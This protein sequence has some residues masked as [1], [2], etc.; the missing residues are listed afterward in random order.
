M[1]PM[2][3]PLL[4]SIEFDDTRLSTLDILC[5]T[6]STGD[7][8]SSDRIDGYHMGNHDHHFLLF[9]DFLNFY[10]KAFQSFHSWDDFL[11]EGI[12]SRLFYDRSELEQLCSFE[13]SAP[14]AGIDCIELQFRTLEHRTDVLSLLSNFFI[15]VSLGFRLPKLKMF[16]IS[17]S[18]C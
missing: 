13:A 15:K 7:W 17:E 3:V 2:P 4:I 5:Y 8:N 6:T 1:W 18:R 12:Q 11:E 16:G 9:K 14:L 10:T